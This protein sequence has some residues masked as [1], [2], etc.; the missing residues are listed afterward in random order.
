MAGSMA[1]CCCEWWEGRGFKALRRGA[2]DLRCSCSNAIIVNT[3]KQQ[4][5]PGTAGTKPSR[6]GTTCNILAQYNTETQTLH[7]ILET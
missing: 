4:Y 3:I 1:G 7:L 5:Q 6:L 2:P